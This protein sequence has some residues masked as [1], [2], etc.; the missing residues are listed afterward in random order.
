VGGRGAWAV[1]A[2]VAGRLAGLAAAADVRKAG[3]IL[4]RRTD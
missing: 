4:A 3:R 2:A 1:P